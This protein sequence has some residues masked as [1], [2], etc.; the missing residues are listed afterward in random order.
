M[1]SLRYMYSVAIAALLTLAVANVTVGEARLAGNAIKISSPA[2]EV[3]LDTKHPIIISYSSVSEGTTLLGAGDSLGCEVVYFDTDE[4][5]YKSSYDQ[6]VRVEATFS[7]DVYT[8][9]YQCRLMKGSLSL[10]EFDLIFAVTGNRLMITSRL[11]RESNGARVCSIRLPVVTALSGE[12]DAKLALPTRSGRLVD[13]AKAE[14]LQ[15]TYKVDWFEPVPIAMAYN[16]RMLGLVQLNSL[17]DQ[18]ISQIKE[19][20]KS[21]SIL[22]EFV[23]RPIAVKPELAFLI[24]KDSTATVTILEPGRGADSINWTSGAA[25]V[26]NSIARNLNP[27]YSGSFIYKILLDSPNASSWTT[28]AD[29]LQL[30]KRVNR[31]TSG[32]KQ[33]VYLIGWQHNGHDTGYPD[34][35]I[36]NERL[37]TIS[38]LR[39]IIEQGKRE[40]A[41]ISVHD[42][43]HDAYKDSPG[44]NPEIIAIDSSGELAEGGKWAG[45]QAYVIS[46]NRYTVLGRERALK[47]VRMLGIEKSIHLDVLSDD[48]DRIDFNQRIPAG[49]QKNI[50]G[51][52]AIVS[53]FNQSG[54]DV[55]SEILT[56]PFVNSISH[57]WNVESRSISIWSAEEQIPLIPMIYHGK[58]TCGS[59]IKNDDDILSSLLYGWTFSDDFTK[60]TSDERIAD[61]YYL[62]TL[63]WSSLA[64]REITDYS[65]SGS[66][67]R[68]TYNANTFVQIDRESNSYKVMRD[69]LV[70]AENFSSM[71]PLPDGSISVYSRSGGSVKVDLPDYWTESKRIRVAYT[72][73]VDRT[74]YRI[75]NNQLTLNASPRVPYRISYLEK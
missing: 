25:A 57:F 22:V 75:R 64:A 4:Q 7:H 3:C 68:V 53:A 50:V 58:V 40:N 29:A 24:Q 30:V 43:Y 17:D 65:K 56:S 62:I 49:R 11:M 41:I 18:L 23:K 60:D 1:L 10:A 61:L 44:W 73:Q 54:I 45:G 34:T 48:P 46:P 21:G 27:L 13:I 12:P 31:I 32:A 28:F 26:R 33:V 9:T 20:P 42:N 19:R 8:A 59:P 47:T 51:K 71:V 37:G 67:E 14:P 2:I 39:A 5:A 35:N 63:P 16:Q 52:L 69:G 74:G 15:R 6:D 66:I 70:I 36:I 55:T 38:D 72:G